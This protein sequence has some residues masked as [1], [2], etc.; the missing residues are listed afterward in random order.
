[1]Q[2]IRVAR[3]KVSPGV[4][5]AEFRRATGLPTA[6]NMIATDWQMAIRSP[7]IR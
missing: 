4:K 2:K 3:S 5:M 1:M 6:T 7:A